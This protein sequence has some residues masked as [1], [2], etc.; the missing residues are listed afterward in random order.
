[1]AQTLE[2]E[3]QTD[4]RF[5]NFTYYVMSSFVKFL[6][7]AGARIVP[8]VPSMNETYT[9]ATLKKLNGVFLPGG[10]GDYETYARF[11]YAKVLELN[12]NG[13]YIPIW[14]TC[15]GFEQLANF[16]AH[17]GDPNEKFYLTHR[18]LPLQFIQDPRD[19]QMFG[20]MSD[21]AFLFENHNYTYN[22]HNWGIPPEKFVTDP[23]LAAMFTATAISVMPDGD[24]RQFVTAMEGKRYPVF[25][26][27]FHPEMASQL[28]IDNYG[29]NHEWLSIK[30]NR[31]FSDQFVYFARHSPSYYGDFLQVQADVIE[32]HPTI[33]TPNQDLVY[34]F[35]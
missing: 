34:V 30:L 8:L 10:D 1:M 33:M 22:G 20:S 19:S 3:M 24:G 2:P 9:L 28:F 16:T 15:M 27:L 35:N 23:G 11:L 31:Q 14:G 7:G 21:E 29:A 12:D 25:G 17:N 18:S 4:P 13:T 32:N 5:S 26:T 6:E